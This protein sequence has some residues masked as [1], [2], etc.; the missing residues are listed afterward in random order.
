M[1]K[2]TP[3]HALMISIKFQEANAKKLSPQLRLIYG[4]ACNN[5]FFNVKRAIK[6]SPKREWDNNTDFAGM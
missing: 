4:H 3:G 1:G 5:V 2:S 6:F